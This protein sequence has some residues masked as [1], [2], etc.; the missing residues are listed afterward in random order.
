MLMIIVIAVVVLG[1]GGAGR[2]SCSKG[3]STRR[4]R[5]PE[6]RVVAIDNALTVNLADG[7]YLKL[8]SRC[9]RPRTPAEEVDTSEA[10]DLAIDEYT[11]KDRGAVHREGPDGDQGGPARED[12]QGL[13]RGRHKQ[14]MGIYYTQSVTQ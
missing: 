9:S 2:S 11:G 6:G 7:H 12:H 13:H 10:F 4:R 14:V 5:R 3:D 8:A 1:G